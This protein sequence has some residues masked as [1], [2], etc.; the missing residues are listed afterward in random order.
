MDFVSNDKS[1]D[2]QQLHWKQEGFY[3]IKYEYGCS[4]FSNLL[5]IIPMFGDKVLLTIDENPVDL[6]FSKQPVTPGTIKTNVWNWHI[7]KDEII[8]KLKQKRI[9]L[10]EQKIMEDF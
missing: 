3:K 9:E 10:K 2:W 7:H 6:M 8:H 4:I 5:E 1:F